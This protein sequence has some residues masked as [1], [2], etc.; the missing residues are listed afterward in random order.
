VENEDGRSICSTGGYSNNTIVDG[1][2]GE[3]E[4]N[5]ARIVHTWNCHDELLA[6][7]KYQ[8]LCMESSDGDLQVFLFMRDDAIEKAEGKSDNIIEG[9]EGDLMTLAEFN[10]NA[11]CT[12][13][14][15][16]DG[17]GEA[18]CRGKF[19]KSSDGSRIRV[20]PSQRELPL[21]SHVTHILWC[22]K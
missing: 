12:A 5:A 20:Y 2:A 22:N 9:S 6:A 17:Y 10:E 13:I 7:L 1:G 19:A 3:N 18:V 11:E 15:D 14:T 21:P 8:K 16:D 4:A